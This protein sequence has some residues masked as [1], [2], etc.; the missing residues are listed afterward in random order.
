MENVLNTFASN[1]MTVAQQ[2][3]AKLFASRRMFYYLSWH[4][5]GTIPNPRNSQIE[6]EI[7]GFKSSTFDC[8]PQGFKVV[9]THIT[10]L[11]NRCDLDINRKML[12]WQP[13]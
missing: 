9:K 5:Y 10:H 6:M 2:L 11:C 1:C 13:G 12:P 3:P 4:Y 7:E 8:G